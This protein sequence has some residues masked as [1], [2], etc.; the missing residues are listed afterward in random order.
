MN[1]AEFG[2]KLHEIIKRHRGVE[3]SKFGLHI[4]SLTAK[5]TKLH[6]AVS[7]LA[8]EYADAVREHTFE[9]ACEFEGEY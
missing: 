5:E 1:K 2:I 6:E 9:R 4:G 7:E 3:D 8:E